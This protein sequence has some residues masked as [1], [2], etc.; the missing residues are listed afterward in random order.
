MPQTACTSHHLLIF[1]T[2]PQP[3]N[4]DVVQ[5]ATLAVH[6][7]LDARRQQDTVYCGLVKWLP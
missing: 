5:R 2:P 1:H 4:K 6:T 3:F 7:D